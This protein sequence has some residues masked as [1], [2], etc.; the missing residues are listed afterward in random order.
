MAKKGYGY[1]YFLDENVI[2]R[3][4]MHDENGKQKA[5]RIVYIGDKSRLTGTELQK[6][7]VRKRENNFREHT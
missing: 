7:S 5:N 4:A 3:E 6:E 2:R 1:F